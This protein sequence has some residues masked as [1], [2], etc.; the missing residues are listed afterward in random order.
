MDKKEL[1]KIIKEVLNIKAVTTQI[2][3]QI[4][5]FV[6]ELGLDYK[7]I[8]QALTFYF[9]VQN[10][11]YQS[12]YGIGIVPHIVDQAKDYYKKEMNKKKKQMKSV[13]D[14]NKQPDI[15]LKVNKVKR[16]KERPKIN[17]D[18]LEVE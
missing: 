8:A 9:E 17:L 12:Q 3:R 6:V 10:N 18:D 14:S 5:R 1:Q 4:N 2:N 7:D 11:A 13:L 15:I 16:K